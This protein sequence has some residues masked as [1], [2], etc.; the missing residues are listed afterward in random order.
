MRAN[1]PGSHGAPNKDFERIVDQLVRLGVWIDINQ[2][3]SHRESIL[4]PQFNNV[5]LLELQLGKVG[6]G[7]PPRVGR[8]GSV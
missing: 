1:R 4:E 3:G 7:A 8:P 6:N 2:S 5:A